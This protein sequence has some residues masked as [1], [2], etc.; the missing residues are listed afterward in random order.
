MAGKTRSTAPTDEVL[1]D[2]ATLNDRFN[3]SESSQREV[4]NRVSQLENQMNS[5]AH[6]LATNTQQLAANSQQLDEIMRVLKSRFPDPNPEMGETSNTG[7]KQWGRD[8]GLGTRRDDPFR[9]GP[10]EVLFDSRRGRDERHGDNPHQR[11]NLPRLYFPSFDGSDPA[12]W[13]ENCEFYFEMFQT[14]DLYQSRMATMHFAG[15]AKDRYRCF[16]IANPFPTWP[17]L[18]EEVMEFFSSNDGNPVDEFK[19]VHQI[20]KVD[21]YVK[22]YLQAKS[23]LTY[24]KGI[25]NE[26][27]YVEGFISGGV[28]G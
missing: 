8:R 24:K 2:L 26:E 25:H 3:Q 28:K 20:G 6:Q 14:P 13:V 16:K 19:R 4:G 7:A 5:A 22:K 11:C 9:T 1:I 18:V 15:E 21:E 27:F 10:E 23:R 12:D 17:V